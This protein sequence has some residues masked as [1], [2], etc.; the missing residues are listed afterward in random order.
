M[1]S[2]DQMT[3][4]DAHGQVSHSSSTQLRIVGI[5]CT[6]CIQL[7]EFHLRRLMG[8]EYF[9]I[10]P[11]TQMAELRWNRG[12]LELPRVMQAIAHLGYGAYPPDQNLD[13]VFA[14]QK[15]M[16][17][18]RLFVAGFAMM[19]VMMFAFPAYWNPQPEV[20]GELTP[21]IDH[22]LKMASFLL[23]LPVLCFSASG[24]F[25]A[26]LRDL[27]QGHVGMDVPVALGIA[28]SFIASFWGLLTGKEVYFDALIMFVFLLLAARAVEAH[29]QRKTAAILQAMTL[30][31]PTTV[32]KCLDFPFNLQYQVLD[33]EALEIGDVVSFHAGDVIEVDGIV[34][35]GTS[36]C[37]EAMMSG[38]SSAVHKGESSTVMAGTLNL[39]GPL[40][41]K[42]TALA[43]QTQYAKI[44]AAMEAAS[45]EK[46]RLIEI[47]DTHASVFLLSILLIAGLTGLAWYWIL[48]ERALWIAISVI[49]V[50]CPCAL[51][52]A[53][54]GVMAGAIA[55]LARRGVI[56]LKGRSIE[57]LAQATHFVF[58]KT[59]TL[60]T[61]QLQVS[62]MDWIGGDPNDA[63]HAEHQK[64]LLSLARA[65]RHPVAQA[66]SRYLSE[67][68]KLSTCEAP[69][70][71]PQTQIEIAGMGSEIKLHGKTY[72]LGKLSFVAQLCAYAE[73][74]A[75]S[76][77]DATCAQTMTFFGSEEGLLAYFILKDELNEDAPGAIAT[78]LQQGKR[79][80]ILSGDS[81]A[82]V[83]SV[84]QACGIAEYHGQM[85]PN[86]KLDFIRHL[87]AQGA[88]VV[89]V[90]DGMNDG[91]ALAQ[92]NVA[93]AMGRGAAIAQTRSDG[94]LLSNRLADLSFAC[95][96][97]KKAFRLIRQNLAWALAYNLIV[98]PL[99]VFGFLQPWHAALGMAMSSLVVIVN[100]LRILRIQ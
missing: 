35:A 19:Q 81:V 29:V 74:Q 70:A 31:Y 12:Q 60:T 73:V 14:R 6:A 79:V 39:L 71:M 27:R 69:F 9:R 26:A 49:V 100:G 75:L 61:G 33:L 25:Q 43:T 24:F 76:L 53:T 17:I 40:W 57:G 44:I 93:I 23:A 41:V 78:L 86:E 37:D 34:L 3:M 51:S 91:P 20:N 54:P 28:L 1:N 42:V 18:W 45:L 92:A 36:A 98:I 48:P 4:V 66:L 15:R 68:L 58:D 8:V 72:R 89:M 2:R 22:L 64:I 90:G 10:H 62:R 38:E 7:I 47:A 46:P 96:V 65:S 97:S 85:S 77:V 11:V 88:R 55:R 21:E 5:R 52:L 94:L 13:E 56:M 63:A 82:A 50:T 30:L 99:A 95:G 32:K 83:R 80:M 67:Q 16:M 59:G 87:Q 84:A